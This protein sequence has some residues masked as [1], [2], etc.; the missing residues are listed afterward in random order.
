MTLKKTVRILLLGIIAVEATV[1]VLFFINPSLLYSPKSNRTAHSQV[2]QLSDSCEE[3]TPFSTQLQD[4]V[5]EYLEHSYLNGIGGVLKFR[6]EI[7]P[8][9]DSGKLVTVENNA[10]YLLDTMHYSYPFLTQKTANLLTE[11]GEEFQLKLKNT[12]LKKTKFVVTSLLRTVSSV[13]R[14]RRH[15]RNAI[16]HSSHLHGTS[17][18]I[19]YE[20]FEN[21]KTLTLAEYDY[22]KEKLAQTIFELRAKEKCWATHER[23]Q[24]CF[25]VVSRN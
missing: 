13:T 19:S 5:H 3:Y 8:K 7:Q 16:K 18:D 2:F 21:P 15:N 23:F 4:N 9:L 10:Y 14:L 12:H 6:R 24:T 1:L 20:Q 11:I 17:F 25:H 22:L